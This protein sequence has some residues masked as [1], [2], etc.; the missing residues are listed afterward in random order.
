MLF[1]GVEEIESGVDG[2]RIADGRLEID[3]EAGEEID[4]GVR[5]VRRRILKLAAAGPLALGGAGVLSGEAFAQSDRTGDTDL[6]S[7]LTG[8]LDFKTLV[9]QLRPIA[10][11]LIV[12]DTPNEEAYLHGIAGLLSRI[13]S[14]PE[15]RPRG[16]GAFQMMPVAQH[17]PLVIYTIVMKP[18][19][20]IRIHDH[21]HYNGVIFGLEGTCRIRNFDIES[22][23][24]KIP[25]HGEEFT[26]RETKWAHVTRGRVSTLSRNRDN[27]HEVVAG[28]DGAELLDVFTYFDR[29]ARSYP[30]VFEDKPADES[31]RLYRVRWGGR[32]P[33][34]RDK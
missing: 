5:L 1:R 10:N 30:I 25:P 22:S 18:H 11:D 24:G 34:D 20:K 17:R 9:D 8:K 21:R 3:H 4:D 2:G 28:P 12:A 26:I 33:S 6:G 13:A 29:A 16:R 32:A 23:D 15:E 31:E 14:F 7:L 27:I 19:A